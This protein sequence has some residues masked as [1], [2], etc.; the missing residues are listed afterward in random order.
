MSERGLT[1]KQAVNDA[2]RRGLVPSASASGEYTEAR[3]LGPA[4]INLD[5]ALRIA[6]ELESDAL[7]RRV[8]EGR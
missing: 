3:D 2:I 4:R 1:F 6:D 5:K 7:S 8:A